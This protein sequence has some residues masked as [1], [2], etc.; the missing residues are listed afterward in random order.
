MANWPTSLPTWEGR[1]IESRQ[2][3]FIRTDMSQGP[4][5]IRRRF[6]ATPS[7][8]TGRII[9]DGNQYAIFQSFYNVDVFGGA[10][11]FTMADPVTGADSTFRFMKP[12][13]VTHLT[14]RQG[15][16]T[17]YRVSLSLERIL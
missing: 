9:L 7:F 5:K 14:G 15:L 2:Q 16:T 11:D 4:S 12:P 13:E 6:S 17:L 8:L 10:G 1:V 3:G